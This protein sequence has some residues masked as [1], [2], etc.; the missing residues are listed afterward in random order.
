MQ[1]YGTNKVPTGMARHR[2]LIIALAA[3]LLGGGSFAAAGGIDLV[4]SWFMTVE[5]TGPDGQTTS[6]VLEAADGE[7]GTVIFDFADGG[8]TTVEVTPR[9][10]SDDG[11]IHINASVTGGQPGAYTISSTHEAIVTDEEAEPNE[12]AESDD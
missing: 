10:A 5:L 1:A 4:K 11:L 3:L 2:T 12:K 9:E 8:R 7:S 6:V